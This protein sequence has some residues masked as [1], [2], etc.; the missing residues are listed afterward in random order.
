METFRREEEV[1]KGRMFVWRGSAL[2]MFTL[3]TQEFSPTRTA[4]TKLLPSV[5]TCGTYLSR[6]AKK[7]KWVIQYRGH[8][9]VLKYVVTLGKS[10][11]K[12]GASG[13]FTQ[14][15]KGFEKEDTP[16]K[17]APPDSQPPGGQT[18]LHNPVKFW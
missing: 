18:G 1:K 2:K 3:L 4:A 7:T 17:Q 15:E 5:K 11:A 9:G 8:G 10:S 14:E 6:L 16:P 12:E 13:E